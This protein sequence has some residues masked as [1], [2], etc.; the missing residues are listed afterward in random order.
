[1][2]KIILFIALLI[3]ISGLSQHNYHLFDG[4]SFTNGGVLYKAKLYSDHF[5]FNDTSYY[6]FPGFGTDHTHAAYGDH[7]HTYSDNILHWD[8][9]QYLPYSGKK[10]SDPGWPYFYTNVGAIAWPSL[11]NRFLCLDGMFYSSGITVGTNPN[12]YGCL[13][14]GYTAFSNTT[15]GQTYVFW[16]ILDGT[17]GNWIRAYHY[18]GT[19]QVSDKINIGDYTT[20]QGRTNEQIIVDPNNHRFDINMGKTRLYQGTA[21]KYLYLD[22]NKEI[23][24]IDLP[25]ALWLTN[26]SKIYYN[27]GNVGIGTSNPLAPLH[28]AGYG[29]IRDSVITQTVQNYGGAQVYAYG[30]QAAKTNATFSALGYNGTAYMGVHY[31]VDGNT[32]KGVR[33]ASFSI[34][35]ST[36]RANW[37]FGKND[38]ITF[39]DYDLDTTAFYSSV[40]RKDLGKSGLPWKNL[41]IGSITA[42]GG[43]STNWNTAY[44][45]VSNTSNPHSVT[46]SQVGLGSV[47]NTALSTWAGSSN[48]TTL[49]AIISCTSFSISGSIGIGTSSPTGLINSISS[50]AN[51]INFDMYSSTANVKSNVVMRKGC[52][53][54]ASPSRINSGDQLGAFTFTGGYD[55]SGTFSWPGGAQAG[56]FAKAEENFSSA[57]N[58]GTC[59]TMETTA[60][61][62]TGS[63]TEKVRVTGSG[64]V[65][66]GTT[67]PTALVDI[68]SDIVR[69]RTAKTPASA[70]A[71]GNAGDICWDASYIYIC[72]S[73]N[74]WK[75]SAITTW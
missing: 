38:T 69:L 3:S 13:F 7:L 30:D 55:A 71:A 43:T 47:E 62:G 31:F 75:R 26:G 5:A 54:P 50:A 49:G 61:G 58:L 52:G 20:Y 63:R 70:T 53:T 51:A 1:M 29:I 45:H 12:G 33:S 2:K 46:K 73:A 6:A 10:S 57:T 66:F 39:V 16:T 14:P 18:A 35:S 74:T 44:S 36:P 28:V 60:P 37:H 21:N 25:G 40:N 8:G 17:L 11:T 4:I 32:S 27:A 22:A 34:G 24:Y 23:S 59:F 56:L 64:N 68:N 48:L 42:T 15:G 72:I 65:G 41:Y 19:T 9:T 67:S